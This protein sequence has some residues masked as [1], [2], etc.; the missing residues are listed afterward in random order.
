MTAFGLLL[1][2]SE[3]HAGLTTVFSLVA[4]VGLIVGWSLWHQK[5]WAKTAFLVW[6]VAAM[7]SGAALHWFFRADASVQMVV[8]LFAFGT[9]WLFL[10]PY[11]RKNA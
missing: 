5:N 1:A 2:F 3:E 4:V 11:V 8:G 7:V 9:V 6:T 10:N